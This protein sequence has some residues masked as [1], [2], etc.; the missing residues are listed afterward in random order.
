[1]D[2]AP[3][4]EPIVEVCVESR[5]TRAE[6][7][8]AQGAI[9]PGEPDDF[10]ALR[11]A[12]GA[13][14]MPD[15]ARGLDYAA[16]FAPRHEGAD[17]VRVTLESAPHPW[18]PGH[19][20]VHLSVTTPPSPVTDD[21]GN[22]V[23]L[24]DVSQ[25][26]LTVANRHL[27]WTD[28]VPE[29]GAPATTRLDVVREAIAGF[30]ATAPPRTTVSLAR[31]AG[32]RGVL[33]PRTMVGRKDAIEDAL[34]ELDS[35]DRIAQGGGRDAIILA[36]TLRRPCVPNRVVVMTDSNARL[37]YDPKATTKYLLQKRGRIDLS[38]AAIGVLGPVDGLEELARSGLG[39][40][41]YAWSVDELIEDLRAITMPPK[42][43]AG[44]FRPDLRYHDD[45]AASARLLA[46]DRDL[47]SDRPLAEGTRLS[48]VW[49]VTLRPVSGTVLTM[50]WEAKG[51]TA[52]TWEMGSVLTASTQDGPVQWQLASADF[53]MATAAALLADVQSMGFPVGRGWDD[54][55]AL[56]DDAAGRGATGDARLPEL[57][58]L[59]AAIARRDGTAPP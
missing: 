1:M 33:L 34:S 28:T 48:V 45:V 3:T 49:D 52:E 10:D 43:T 24:V 51:P 19:R 39:R 27:P 47:L 38:V 54:L 44:S 2:P 59:A 23:F 31:Y 17:P 22:V 11:A 6:I 9:T 50:D 40:A 4:E 5:R 8:A 14:K 37:D 53:K 41:T 18:L 7:L 30:A 58:R 13:G 29:A 20:F 55:V 12:L 16:A 21:A 35:G 26:M 56:A 36:D 46:D 15:R 57:V 32:G 42:T 25:S